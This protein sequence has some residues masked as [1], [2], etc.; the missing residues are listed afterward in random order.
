MQDYIAKEATLGEEQQ[1]TKF[2][3]SIDY[4]KKV[5]NMRRKAESQRAIRMLQP[6]PEGDHA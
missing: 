3:I 2:D 4:A 5:R 1:W 6:A